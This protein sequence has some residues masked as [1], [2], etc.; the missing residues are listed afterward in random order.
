MVEMLQ[1]RFLMAL[2]DLPRIKYPKNTP[3]LVIKFTEPVNPK[4]CKI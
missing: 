4:Q 2:P 1:F 3:D